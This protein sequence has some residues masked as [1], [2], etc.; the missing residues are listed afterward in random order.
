[1]SRYQIGLVRDGFAA[2]DPIRQ[3]AA[4]LFYARLFELAPEVRPLFPRD[5]SAQG[6]KLMAAIAL[7]VDNLDRIGGIRP[8]IEALARRHVDYGATEAH[9]SA[10]GEALLW[11]LEQGLGDKLTAEA[12]EAWTAAYALLSGTMIAASRSEDSAA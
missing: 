5:L 11:A 3:T 6:A 4:T 1:M 7:V 12:V 10:V 2:I 8:E 9:Y